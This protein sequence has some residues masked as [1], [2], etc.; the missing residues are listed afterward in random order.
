MST[1]RITPWVVWLIPMSFCAFQFVLRLFPGNVQTELMTEF[2]VDAT[3]FGTFSAAYYFGYA[4]LQIPMAILME[5]F[6]PRLIITLSALLCALGCW[7]MVSTQMWELAILSR[8][9]IGVGSVVG[10]LGTTK[11]IVDWFPHQHH[12]KMIGISMSIGLLGALYGG[13][14]INL[15]VQ[16]SNW[17]AVL[18]GLGIAAA[19]IA[20]AAFVLVRSPKNNTVST[21]NSVDSQQ[22]TSWLVQIIPLLKN[23][24]FIILAIANFLMV[25]C[26]EGF[27]DVWGVNYLALTAGI[28]KSDASLMTSFIFLGM[29]IGTPVLSLIADKTQ[30]HFKLTSLCGVLMAISLSV[31]LLKP[32]WFSILGLKTLMLFI[33]LL[34]GYQALVF[35]IGEGLVPKHLSNIAIATLNCINMFGGAFFHKT[36]GKVM[37]ITSGNNLDVSGIA[38]YDIKA[39]SIGLAVIPLMALLGGLMLLCAKN[40]KVGA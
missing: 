25:G 21:A 31:L 23:K 35:V 32:E 38:I 29:L 12:T 36:I 26:L 16:Q 4:G 7:L 6:G 18:S 13:K 10:F 37:D 17:H 1:S 24:T 14:P 5:K 2:H 40:K 30:A 39:Y 22:S 33:G 3:A 19:V 28:A 27:A 15:L 8:F 20:L 34:S 9:M 11:V